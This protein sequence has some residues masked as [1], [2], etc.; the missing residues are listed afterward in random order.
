MRRF[1]LPIVILVMAA[2]PLSA[3]PAGP[4]SA[5]RVAGQP[6]GTWYW[7][8]DI[9]AMTGINGTSLPT[10]VTFHEDGTLACAEG[11][12]F[13]GF[14]GAGL[15]YSGGLGTWEKERRG[16]FNATRLGFVFDKASGVL[17]GISR[18]RF[19]FQYAG[20]FDEITGT[21]FVETLP[22]STGP[23]TCPDPLDPDAVWMPA[24]PPGGF[25]ATARLVHTLPVP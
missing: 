16:T 23:M 9:S 13:G 8:T 22:C 3:Q 4:M 11:N 2:A 5:P 6:W 19:A 1:L 18:S 25:P 15:V 17:K 24:S 14:P 20:R 7:V 12:S 21:L 10:V